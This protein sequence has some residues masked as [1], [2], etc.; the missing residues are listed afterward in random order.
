MQNNFLKL[1]VLTCIWKRANLTNIILNYYK[2]LKQE[3]L[4]HNIALELVAVGSEGNT[5]KALCVQNDFDYIE[6]P[7][8]PLGYKWNSGLVS[9]KYKKIDAVVIIGSDDLLNKEIF[10]LY[11]EAIL[12]GALYVGFSQIYIYDLQGNKILL[13]KNYGNDV[14]RTVG[15]GRC[16]HNYYLDMV[17]WKLWS[18]K[19]DKG[20]DRDMTLRLTNYKSFK[21]N[22]LKHLRFSCES[23]AFYPVDIKTDTNIWTYSHIKNKSS[24]IEFD[25]SNFLENKYPY[26]VI[27]NL[28]KLKKRLY[29]LLTQ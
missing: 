6:A 19:I 25:A 12:S 10:L 15:L 17:N 28:K 4:E 22:A 11:K 8:S 14:V 27:N 13:L 2:K 20:L 3:L 5:S 26:S 29:G 24:N 7:N 23:N 1:G 9:L 18:N 16:I 21:E